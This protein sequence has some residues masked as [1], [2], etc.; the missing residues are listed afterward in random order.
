MEVNM[1]RGSS[2]C[3]LFCFEKQ[4]K[5]WPHVPGQMPRLSHPGAANDAAPTGQCRTSRRDASRARRIQVGADGCIRAAVQVVTA[6]LFAHPLL[7]PGTWH[8]G[9]FRHAFFAMLFFFC[10]AFA[11]NGSGIVLF[12]SVLI[13]WAQG[14]SQEA[15][16]RCLR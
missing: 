8:W 2:S 16:E 9:Q 7:R 13:K 3:L 6:S 5:P 12:F 14:Y 11:Q 1:L 10:L 4:L 15:W